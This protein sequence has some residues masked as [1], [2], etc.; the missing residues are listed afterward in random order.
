[1]DLTTYGWNAERQAEF[2]S[3]AADGLI[4]GRVVRVHR[5]H[6]QVATYLGEVSAEAAGRLRN[7]ATLRSDLA[8]IGDFV[9][10]RTP[11]GDGPS[12]IERTLPR[13]TAL[14]RTASGEDRPQLL[15][16]NVDVVFIVTAP[17]GDFNLPR[18]Q[19]FLE[20]V[21]ASGA[22]PAIILNKSDLAADAGGVVQQIE[23][24][25]GGVPVHMIS[26]QHGEGT[27]ILEQYFC[28][29][30]T[31]C[32]IGS[33]GVG[34]STLTNALLGRAE[35]VTQGVRAHDSRG[36][37]TTTD[38]RLFVRPEGGCI[39]DSP[40]I[41]GI[42]AWDATN[43]EKADNFEDVELVARS[44]KFRDCRHQNEPNCAVRLAL[45]NG[46]LTAERV[47]LFSARNASQSV[48]AR[49]RSKPETAIG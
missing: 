14:I 11:A 12:T 48:T 27:G 10:L 41:R 49:S 9:A 30:S 23:D 22:A 2:A 32:L 31:V 46:T 16:A 18:I 21:A 45:Q 36:R 39:I 1:M 6:F 47:T 19:R 35:Q 20:L 44:C 29:N 37:H 17:D 43:V 26:A 3:D 13:V 28:G 40:G 24:V 15:A 33:S 7:H 25:A 5:S 42:V 34:K 8:G 38:R 4:P